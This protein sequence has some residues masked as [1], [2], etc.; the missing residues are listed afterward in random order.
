VGAWQAYSRLA[1]TPTEAQLGVRQ[2]EA[3]LSRFQKGDPAREFKSGMPRVRTL[4]AV[5]SARP[6]VAARA[7]QA[8]RAP[9]QTEAAAPRHRVVR[10]PSLKVSPPALP[11]PAA[12]AIPED[13]RAKF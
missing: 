8:I 2:S 3:L 13:V 7:P 12:P 6:R 5:P 1:L 11:T 4:S 9:R 10:A